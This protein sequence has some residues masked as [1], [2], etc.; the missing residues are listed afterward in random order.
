MGVDT[1]KT[2]GIFLL[3]FFFILAPRV[4]IIIPN[5]TGF[6]AVMIG[7]LL[8]FKKIKLA[9]RNKWIIYTLL[10]FVFL[11][12]YHTFCAILYGHDSS[13][14]LSILVSVFISLLF[15]YLLVAKFYADVNGF[16]LILNITSMVVVIM[17]VNSFIIL[18]EFYNPSAKEMLESILVNEKGAN[19]NYLEHAFRFR[20]FSS[21]GGSSLSIVNAATIWFAIAL[22][23]LGKF[24]NLQTLGMTSVIAASNIF[25]GRTGL[26]FGLAFVLF[27]ITFK[28]IPGLFKQGKG[29]F[30]KN[31]LVIFL[32]IILLPPIE[33]SDEVMN[34]AFE[35]TA[36]LESGKVE[37]ASSDDLKTMLF[38]PDNPFHFLFGIGFFEG[39][40]NV[41][42]RTDSGYLKTL[43]SLGFLLSTVLY[44][45]LFYLIYKITT[46]DKRLRLLIFPVAIFLIF[47][48][49]KEPFLYQNFLSRILTLFI[50]A[51]LYITQ[52]QSKTNGNTHHH[53]S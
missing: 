28:Y 49:I 35:W 4:S 24:S 51:T 30:A 25:T 41:Y 46:I 26:A 42:M 33:I 31:I 3:L 47:V 52:I 20:G 19:I 34:W 1:V 15:S 32:V 18:I 48:E 53:I 10:L 27:F 8:S 43:L 29:H 50:G 22:C 9:F 44:G 45:F 13:F 5:H 39:I 14:F 12:A 16:D 7:V 23:F 40:N 38:I 21:S 36:G 2:A 37:S 17:F 6:I 11:G